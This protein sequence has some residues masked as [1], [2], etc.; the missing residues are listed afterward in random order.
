MAD[1]S[2]VVVGGTTVGANRVVRAKNGL[3]STTFIYAV[4]TATISVSD[5]VDAMT[6]TYGLTIA[7]ISGTAGATEY[8][9]AQGQGGAEAVAG[10]ALTTT[11]A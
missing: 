10:I 11:F 7:G 6:S 2:A 3:G 5:A 8:V 9:A 4:T 1:V